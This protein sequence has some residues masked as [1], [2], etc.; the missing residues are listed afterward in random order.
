MPDYAYS[1]AMRSH[2][3]TWT[4]KA[5]SSFLENPPGHIKGTSMVFDE[6]LSEVARKEI[7]EYLTTLSDP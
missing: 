1:N 7:V 2:G 5:L 4:S 3:G 6:S